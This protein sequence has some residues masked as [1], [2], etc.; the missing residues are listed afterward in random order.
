MHIKQYCWH[1]FVPGFFNKTGLAFD[2]GANHLQFA[3][4]L[5]ST[6]RQVIAVEPNEAL[7][8]GTSLPANLKTVPAAVF[9]K[10][11]RVNLI[12]AAIDD[13]S[14]VEY[15][16]SGSVAAITL[17]QL[18][19]MHLDE[20]EN[21]DF[22]KMDIEGDE[23]DILESTSADTL[24]RIRQMTVE[25]HDFINHDDIPRIRACIA[26]LRE[27]GFVC[28]RFSLTTYGDVL[29]VN[30]ALADWSNGDI[31]WT[32]A[33]FKFLRGIKRYIRRIVMGDSFAPGGYIATK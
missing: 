15:D 13:S 23:L 5:A 2:L 31:W 4:Y 3:N 33:R 12:N 7:F 16:N 26:R 20:A 14:T 22:V 19:A 25:F 32:L 11:G 9:H 1:S 30:R 28:L 29:F 18:F 17:E 27:L 8:A 24:R 21:V 10:S 6:H